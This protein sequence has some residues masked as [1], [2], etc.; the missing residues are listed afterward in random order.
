[1]APMITTAAIQALTAAYQQ[2]SNQARHQASAYIPTRRSMSKEEAFN[3]LGLES[4]AS[5]DEIQ[6]RFEQITAINE[7]V[8]G[9]C[10][11]PFLV[12]KVKVA[13]SVLLGGS[14]E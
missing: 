5:E 1:M 9:Y 7:P 13:R 14:S 10:G 11:S 4:S 6:K 3:V 12:Q 8:E 2:V